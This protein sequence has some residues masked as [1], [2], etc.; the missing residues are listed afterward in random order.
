[1][2]GPDDRIERLHATIRPGTPDDLA[3]I[4]SILA[5]HGNDGPIVVADIVGPYMAYLISRGATWVAEVEDRIVA[6]AAAIDTG[7]SRHL[8]DLFVHPDLIGRGIGRPL[9][10]A[11][12]G[13]E[14]PRTTSASD[15]PRAVPL[16]V[17]A[18][19]MP[20]WPTLYLQGS[21]QALPPGNPRLRPSS[22]TAPELAALELAWTGHDRA[23][24]HGYWSAMADADAF[25]I[26]D[27]ADVAAFGYARVRQLVATRVLDRLLIHPDADPVATTLAALQRTG[28]HGGDVM[29]C[30]LGPH[31]ALRPLLEA[32]YRL[33]DRDQFMASDP[34]IVDPARLIPNPGML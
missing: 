7:R 19:M 28:R 16:Y 11:V 4:R 18:G 3:T 10:A 24:D 6:V 29:A 33:L 9:L 20:L 12:L 26:R 1:M 32:G 15:D 21:V 13:D 8:A 14:D 31:P 30:V 17:R 23:A 34:D 25:V 2:A 22:A 27:G 5:A